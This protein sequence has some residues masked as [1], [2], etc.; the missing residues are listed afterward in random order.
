MKLKLSDIWP[1]RDVVSAT[2]LGAAALLVCNL[3]ALF[4]V[5]RPPG[6]SA[7]ELRALAADL[8]NE[9]RQRQGA[10][11]RTRDIAGKVQVG[12]GEAEHFMD[13]WFLDR[14]TMSSTVV[15]D[16]VEMGHQAGLRQK[17]T[18]LST[19]PVEGTDDLSMLT[20]SVNYEGAYADLMKLLNEI[21]RSKRLVIIESLQAAP[22]QGSNVLNINVRLN[23][24]VRDNVTSPLPRFAPDSSTKTAQNFPPGGPVQ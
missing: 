12:R 13:A 10:L 14:R 16:L 11:T 9:V 2:W 6:G 4:F 21:D 3:V 5:V 19:E 8:R 23:G 24:F 15:A 7:Q 18:Q 1:P 20:V 22:Q 17:E